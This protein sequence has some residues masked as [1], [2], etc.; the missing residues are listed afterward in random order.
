MEAVDTLL[1]VE[2]LREDLRD[3]FVVVGLEVL[4]VVGLRLEQVVGVAVL[5]E[6]EAQ[7]HVAWDHWVVHHDWVDTREKED[8]GQDHQDKS[9]SEAEPLEELLIPRS[10][11]VL[12]PRLSIIVRHLALIQV[13]ECV[14]ELEPLK[15][16]KACN[17]DC[18]VDDDFH[19]PEEGHGFVQAEGPH[20]QEPGVADER[21]F[22]R[23]LRVTVPQLQ[24]GESE[25]VKPD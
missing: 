4:D 16:V 19:L 23:G 5:I 2:C 25:V 6:F 14:V 15:Q 24:G 22:E 8:W 12:L 10:L 21:R 11:S 17:G 1:T 13:V 9:K 7:G 20:G 3:G 18:P